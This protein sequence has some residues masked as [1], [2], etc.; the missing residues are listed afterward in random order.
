MTKKKPRICE[1]LGV[2]PE[3]RF[4]VV[5]ESGRVC[6]REAFITDDGIVYAAVRQRMAGV[7]VCMLINGALRIVRRPY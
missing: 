2:E 4:R 1:I 7:G 5:G 3:E 6:F